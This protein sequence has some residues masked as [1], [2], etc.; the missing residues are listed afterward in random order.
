MTQDQEDAWKYLNVQIFDR[1]DMKGNFFLGIKVN[2]NLFVKHIAIEKAK[3]FKKYQIL[4]KL[5]RTL[6]LLLD[7]VSK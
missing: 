6:H 3:A 7:F 1:V 5:F 4:I 2:R